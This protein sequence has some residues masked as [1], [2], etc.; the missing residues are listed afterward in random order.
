MKCWHCEAE[1]KYDQKIPFKATCEKCS[2]YLH[3][4]LNCRYYK[5]GL[6]NDCLIPGTEP[7]ADRAAN[8]YCEEFAPSNQQTSPKQVPA[9]VE[10]KLFGE[11]PPP[12][13]KNSF[14]SLF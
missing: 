6:P 5:I 12:S 4:C 1:N 3:S 2:Y 11:S 7:I 8:N 13:S 9:D 10:K 14:D